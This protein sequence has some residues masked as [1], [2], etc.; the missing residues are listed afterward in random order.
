MEDEIITINCNECKCDFD[1]VEG[2]EVYDCPFCGSELKSYKIKIV[3]D[4]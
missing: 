3:E 4:F 1:D 2:K